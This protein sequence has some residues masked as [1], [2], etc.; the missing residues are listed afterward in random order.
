MACLFPIS[1]PA[2]PGLVQHTGFRHMSVPCGKCPECLR[3]RQNGYY[4][5]TYLELQ[6]YLSRCPSSVVDSNADD[7][8]RCYFLTLT[9]DDD[10]LP[11]NRSLHF[12]HLTTQIKAF[13]LR[14]KRSSDI[15][16]SYLA[17]SEYGS[18]T[19]RPHYHVLFI[20]ISKNEVL[21]F[22]DDWRRIH[23]PKSSDCLRPSDGSEFGR[24]Q[25]GVMV[26]DLP[27]VSDLLNVCRY[28]SKYTAKK[29]D[30]WYSS[31]SHTQRLFRQVPQV[32]TSRYFGLGVSPLSLRS[33]IPN[34]LRQRLSQFLGDGIDIE[35]LCNRLSLTIEDF[36]Y[37]LPTYLINKL[38]PYDKD[39][40]N[41]RDYSKLLAG[42]PTL[43]DS[44]LLRAESV[45][46]DRVL[47]LYRE[48][49][50]LPNATL[51]QAY[52]DSAFLRW[53]S[54]QAQLQTE[55]L[56]QQHETRSKRQRDFS[57]F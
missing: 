17:C 28:I 23:C 18:N 50:G 16:F 56:S 45:A 54:D 52:Q 35:D 43:R 57:K 10:H 33:D 34:L 26:Q 53:Q 24:F 30:P 44:L 41:H 38:V 12:Q 1:V 4:V 13:K 46:A 7:I 27:T 42:K 32:V 20:G 47:Q 39:T 48:F 36:S 2:P 31:L 25:I 55:Q 11:A 49:S 29:Y 22:R 21:R 5:R 3:S 40:E 8:H 14:R 6:G 37:S 9:Y 19:H 51:T 15:L